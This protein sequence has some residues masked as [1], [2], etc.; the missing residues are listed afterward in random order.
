MKLIVRV[1]MGIILSCAL[2]LSV[3]GGSRRQWWQL[4]QGLYDD[5]CKM[6]LCVEDR[7]DSE[8]ATAT[9]G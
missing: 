5:A 4:D 3:L 9:K 1:S 2:L 7:M 8:M 6:L